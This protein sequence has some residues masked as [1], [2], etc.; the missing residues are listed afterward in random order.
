MADMR[1]SLE[2]LKEKLEKKSNE[3]KTLHEE[4]E[5]AK[6]ERG[7]PAFSRHFSLEKSDYSLDFSSVFSILLIDPK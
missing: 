1:R 3:A 6:S 5:S 4:L 7:L 2:S